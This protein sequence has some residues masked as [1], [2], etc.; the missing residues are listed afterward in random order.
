MTT[1]KKPFTAVELLALPDDGKRYELIRGVLITMAPASAPHGGVTDQFGWVIG[2]FVRQH[3]L[4]RTYAAETGIYIERDPDTVRAPDYAFMSHERMRG[5]P[6][7]SGYSEIIPDLVVEVVAGDY[8]ASAVD[9]KTRMWLDAGVRMVLVA[10]IESREI[11][12]HH[13]DGTVRRFGPGDTLTCEPV[14][15]GFACP[16]A[17][18]FAY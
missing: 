14:L 15:P 13:D 3:H 5:A 1:A 16:I 9:S 18:I 12:A 11:V 7:A 17:D 10:Y 8:R 6:P 2:S 4:G